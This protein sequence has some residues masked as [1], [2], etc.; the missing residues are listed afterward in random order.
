V[1]V[2]VVTRKVRMVDSDR[3]IDE[4]NRYL[5]S[6][7]GALYQRAELDDFQRGH[8]CGPLLFLETTKSLAD[9]FLVFRRDISSILQEKSSEKRTTGSLTLL[10]ENLDPLS[11][12]QTDGEGVSF[13]PI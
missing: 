9:V 11:L 5:G 2:E 12:T 1:K 7:A 8:D 4:P 3:P 10:M 13:G 6:S